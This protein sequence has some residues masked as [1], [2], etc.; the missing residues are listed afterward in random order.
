MLSG[1]FR[2]GYFYGGDG[3]SSLRAD[4]RNAAGFV[5]DYRACVTNFLLPLKNLEMEL[6]Q[7]YPVVDEHRQIEPIL[8]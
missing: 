3:E 5:R 8:M 1:A 2:F 7:E 4:V 6:K